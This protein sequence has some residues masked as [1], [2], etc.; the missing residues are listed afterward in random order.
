MD[1]KLTL[2]S[3]GQKNECRSKFTLNLNM[4]AAKP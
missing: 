4:V 3:K 1:T 2:E